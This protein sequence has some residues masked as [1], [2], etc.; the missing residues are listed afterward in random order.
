MTSMK[1]LSRPKFLSKLTSIFEER[2][3]EMGEEGTAVGVR[4]RGG[5]GEWHSTKGINECGLVS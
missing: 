2:E 3:R 4:A 5:G 1:I